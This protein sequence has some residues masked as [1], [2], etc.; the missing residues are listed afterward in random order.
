MS[1]WVLTSALVLIACEPARGFDPALQEIVRAP[2]P[3]DAGILL[4]S[5]CTTPNGRL[6]VSLES[7]TGPLFCA[8]LLYR[9]GADRVDDP[10]TRG[11]VGIEG[12][13]LIAVRAGAYCEWV[14][15]PDGGLDFERSIAIDEIW[16]RLDPGSEYQGQLRNFYVREGGVRVG[17]NQFLLDPGFFTALVPCEYP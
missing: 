1:R 7:P 10:A 8:V 2:E 11:L 6:I 12:Y 13:G 5:A 15:A 17:R 16:G 4:G 9:K 3:I 14:Q